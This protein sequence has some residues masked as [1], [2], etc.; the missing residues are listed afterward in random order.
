MKINSFKILGVLL[1]LSLLV[2]VTTSCGAS[3]VTI[4]PLTISPAKVAPD[5]AVTISANI[6]SSEEQGVDYCAELTINDENIESRDIPIGPGETKTIT[7]QYSASSLG[8]YSVDVN[9]Q[10]GTF[11]VAKP[12][13]FKI[14][15]ITFNPEVIVTGGETLVSA[16]VR[17]VGELPGNYT[18]RLV[19]DGEEISTQEIYLEPDS[20][21][22][23]SLPFS[24]K[25]SGQHTI[26]FCQ[27]S[28][29]VTALKPA[30]FQATS[31]RVT[32]S[33][34]LIGQSATVE[35]TITNIGE[36][37]DVLPVVLLVNGSEFSSK[38]VTLEPGASSTVSFTITQDSGGYYNL[39]I[40]GKS[41]SLTVVDLEEYKNNIY[42][43]TISYPPDYTIKDSDAATVLIESA[44]GGIAV[45][46][47]KVSVSS[48]PAEYFDGIVQGKKQQLPDW[49]YSA[50]TEVVENGMTIGYKFDYTNT[51]N[52]KLWIGKGMVVKKAGYGYYIVYTTKES[53][54]DDHSTIAATC[55]DSFVSPSI[56]TDS[57]TNEDVGVS[58]TIPTE[59]SAIETNTAAMPVVVTAPYN[60]AT[61]LGQLYIEVVSSGTTA[62]QFVDDLIS[63]VTP[64]GY[65][66]VKKG[67][68]KFAS[69][70]TGYETTLTDSSKV[71]RVRVISLASGTRMYTFIF[72]GEAANVDTQANS[73]TQ[74]ASTLEVSAPATAGYDKNET[75]FLLA[76]E[77]PTL[78]PA[79]TEEAPGD[80]IGAIFSGLVKIN[81]DL[82][83]VAD[84]AERWTVSTDGKTYTF[85]LRTNARFHDG[86]Q[87][88][89]A[90]V[91][92]SW[93]RA[94]DPAT[95]STKASNFLSDIVGAKD[96]L[97]GEVPSISGIKVIN[98]TTLEVTIDAAK[99]YFLGKLA[100][101]VAYIV[102]KTNVQHGSKWYETPNGTG[103]FKL[104][105]WK[106]DTLMAL[107]RNDD[108]YLEPAK[109][110]Y[111]VYKLFAGYPMIL[112]E[113]GEIDV[114]SVSTNDLDKVLDPGNPL[115]KELLTGSSISTYY[116]ALN[117]TK[118]PFDDPKVRRAFA[119]ALDVDKII[120]VSLKGRAER[121]AG[122]VPPRI[123]GHN[124]DLQPIAY[125][126]TQAKQLITESK[127]Q[128]VDNLPTVTMYVVY[129][130]GPI[131]E[132]MVAMWQQNLGV[133]VRIEAI[134]E[135]EDYLARF[136]R[137][138]FQVVYWGWRAD[139]VDPQNFLE[140]LFHSQSPEN[141]MAYSNPAVDTALAEAGIE[142]DE[143][144]RIRK[145]QD[146]E[147]MILNDLP[148]I[149]L[150]H[151]MKTYV[152]VKPY[153]KGYT[154]TPIG[155]NIW[156]DTYVTP[157]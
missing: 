61:V 66:V 63:Q 70:T 122:Y 80:Y 106:Q 35:A 124:P 152:L 3:R 140:V 22:E 117:P 129:R 36:A 59:W 6:L 104:K 98:D 56:F 151:S 69:G 121:T 86:K 38:T 119:L 113:S 84:L 88:T 139:Y 153:V 13:E 133:Q 16:D 21:Q 49:T 37:E 107:E 14:D 23:V 77:I 105:E 137:R 54:W 143:A 127:Y 62:Q 146:I 5:Q 43:Y 101:P 108:F 148:A 92:Y 81:K 18:A 109:L 25:S 64:S 135:Y 31:I 103:P 157:H 116:V 44:D 154:L 50:R 136:H 32:P 26:E 2:S 118:P 83:I 90:D 40:F 67:A 58:L 82:E 114:T 93:E 144:I 85:Y 12:A 95:E 155:I 79:L 39:G 34:V 73:I 100:Q 57:Y 134:S 150:F 51:V 24:L 11:E 8:S 120:E 138:E 99:Q 28:Q 33:S 110:R 142:I 48:T 19:I 112:Y 46:V 42:F 1:T 30:E 45:L 102:D 115:N 147:K 141:G 4:S 123:P 76:G 132:A 68:Y 7:F 10:L 20:S 52:G 149:P 89:A 65:Q 15:S 41:A 125:D 47:D 72:S 126:P 75:L 55:V 78:D 60:E 9:G 71:N 128:S 97:A 27:I 74:I 29:E 130:A 111:V 87:V 131:Q 91:K 94:C 145:Y 156:T 53:E 96:M 17:N